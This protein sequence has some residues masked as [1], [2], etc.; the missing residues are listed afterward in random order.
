[1]TKRCL[2]Y[3]KQFELQPYDLGP[4]PVPQFLVCEHEWDR[5]RGEAWELY[6][7]SNVYFRPIILSPKA[8]LLLIKLSSSQTGL[9]LLPKVPAYFRGGLK[10]WEIFFLKIQRSK[11]TPWLVMFHVYWDTPSYSTCVFPIECDLLK[12]VNWI[13][14]FIRVKEQ[15]ISTNPFC[16]TNGLY[17]MIIPTHTFKNNLHFHTQGLLK[18]NCL[19]LSSS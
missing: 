14:M 11:V 15:S 1:M 12:L 2:I 17:Y 4:R 9:I 13:K 18:A 5:G 6:W 3:R 10:V 7:E 16:K 8:G 19:N